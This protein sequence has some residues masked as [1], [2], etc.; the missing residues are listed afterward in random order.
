MNRI[1]NSSVI[2]DVMWARAKA[3]NTKGCSM[4]LRCS[5]PSDVHIVLVGEGSALGDWQPAKGIKMLCDKL[6]LWWIPAKVNMLE[7]TQYKFV[8]MRGDDVLAWESGDNRIWI[9]K[10]L[11]LGE[12]RTSMTFEPRMAG[13]AI[14]VFSVRSAGTEG[15]GD[16]ISLGDFAQWAAM[17]GMKVVQTLPIND[18]TI[19]HSFKDSY[20]YKAISIY[21]LH[22]LYIRVSAIDPKADVSELMAVN[23][24]T[25]V[26]YEK[27]DALKWELFRQIFKKKGAATLKSAKFLKFFE[28]NENWLKTY[29]VFSFLRDKF[30]SADPEQWDKKYRVYSEKLEDKIIAENPKEIGLYYFLQ[31]HADSQLREARNK[32]RAAGVVFKGDIPIGVSRH[33]VEVWKEPHLFNLNGQAGAP[34]DD[35][36]V[37][38][39]NW[40]FPTYNWH[41]MAADNYTW[42]K[43]RFTKMADYF[44]MYRIDHILGFF[45]IWEIPMPE[46]SGLMG[47][48]AP[49]LPFSREELQNWGLPMFEER[50]MGVDD[51]DH[52]TLF[53]RDPQYPNMY[54]PRISAQFTDRYNNTLDDYEKDKYN[55]LY[56]HYFYHRHNDFWAGQ[57]LCKLPA[58]IDATSMLCCAEDLGMIPDCVGWVL[59]QLQVATLE[60]QRMPKDPHELF[61][62]TYNYPYRSV[63][64]SSTHDMDPIRAW[65]REDRWKT[66]K[67]Y[68]DTMGW[69]GEAPEDASGD[70]C[71]WIVEA[72]LQSNSMAAI[73]PWQDYMAIDEKLRKTDAMDERI[74]IPANPEHYW[75]YRMHLSV[76]ELKGANELNENF[77]ELIHNSNR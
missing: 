56:T 16:F 54:H 39:Q 31:Y 32:A 43:N 25:K 41:K 34:P 55:A 40:G 7:G 28:A 1:T 17:T 45:R 29:A 15:I 22:P 76:E 13:V 66:Q 26:D 47:H 62:N 3:D 57:A 20:P 73:L 61:T 77:K 10:N 12:F 9:A 72:H 24:E 5:V 6:P 49:S 21:A 58:L 75:R 8:M 30:N 18:T 35:F 65:W 14:P 60:I 42:W 33:S 11:D 44:D 4:Y 23:S 2:T 19:T 50:Y 71:R 59:N 52:N 38:G 69:W 51:S 70:I 37:D 68:N 64:A 36:S 53:V 63:A 27:V 67:Y 46:K 74:N 48:F